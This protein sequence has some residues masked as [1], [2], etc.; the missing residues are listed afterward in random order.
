MSTQK[1]WL[2]I[3]ATSTAGAYFVNFLL[4]NTFDLVIAASRQDPHK[5]AWEYPFLF[6]KKDYSQKQ[7]LIF[8]TY[9]LNTDVDEQFKIF[10]KYLPTHVINFACLAMVGQSWVHPDDWYQTNVIGQ[11]KL[12]QTMSKYNQLDLYIHFSTPEVYG[13]NDKWKGSDYHLI[14]LRF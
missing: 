8:E 2:V 1:C 6:K 14:V 4:E 7:R 10:K 5:K 13:N 3:G 12:M 9:D 11:G